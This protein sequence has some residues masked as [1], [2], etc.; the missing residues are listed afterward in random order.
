[1]E[2]PERTHACRS[3]TVVLL[4]SLCA[5]GCASVSAE[6][7]AKFTSDGCSLFPD[8][9]IRI[10]ANW[11]DCCLEHDFS[12]WQGGTTEERRKADEQL[13]ECV[14]VRTGDKTLAETMYRGVRAGGHPAFP[15]WY[16]WAYGWPYGRGYA[17]LT[18]EDRLQ[19][20]HKLDEYR[21]AHPAGYC[22]EKHPSAQFGEGTKNSRQ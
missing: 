9:S 7:L 11:C 10:S 14:R 19:A 15:M 13:R 21:K 5:A 1:M 8:G 18:D 2:K 16:R 3:I 6:D 20:N 17:P 12:Y 4:A 22:Q